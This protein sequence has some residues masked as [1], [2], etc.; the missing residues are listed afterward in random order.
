FNRVISLGIV[1]NEVTNLRSKVAVTFGDQSELV[2]G[3]LKDANKSATF[4][5]LWTTEEQKRLEDCLIQFPPEEVE[6]RRW[7]KIATA[8]GNRT[9]QQVA[10]RVQ[11]YFIKLAK[12]GLPVPGRT[13]TVGTQFK[14]AGHRHHRYNTFSQHSTFLQSHEPPVYMSDDDDSMS[15]TGSFGGNETEFLQTRILDYDSDDEQIPVELRNTPEYQQL[16]KLKQLRKEKVR[17]ECKMFQHTGY[18]CDKCDC[19]PI[20]GTRWHCTDC[21]TEEAVD[22][23]DYCA[24][25]YYESSSHN[26]SHKLQAIDTSTR[27]PVLDA[28]Y[29]RFMP[30]DYNYLD[31]NYM[32]AN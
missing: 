26:S 20:I 8:L 31:P 16:V 29:M 11:K 1:P 23:C 19:E 13:P 30:G 12:A 22:F 18:K 17:S 4:N 21:P 10:S 7:Q 3:R 25:S 24:D 2:R 5:V 14:K 9:T 28:D 27:E 32:P 15:Y 6:A